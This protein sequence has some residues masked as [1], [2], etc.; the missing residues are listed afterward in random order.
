MSDIIPFPRSKDKL[1]RD[2]K[3]AYNRDDLEEMY[4]L[5][6]DYEEHYELD[7][8][9]SLLKCAMLYRMNHFLELREEAIILLKQ[10]FANY[11]ELVIYYV[12]SLNGLG[13]YF[14][15]VEVI[16]QIIDEVQNHK[17]R[18]ELLPLKSYALSQLEQHNRHAASQLQQ[19]DTLEIRDQINTILALIDNS[20]YTYKD[21][22]ANLLNEADIRNNVVSIMLEYLRFAEYEAEVH[23]NKFNQSLSVVPKNLPG[24]EQTAMKLEVIPEVVKCL[25]NEGTQLI[26]EALHVMNNHAILLYPI[27]I[28]T[29]GAVS[30][31]IKAYTN[32]FKSMLGI[33][34]PQPVDDVSDFIQQLDQLD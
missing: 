26:E 22:V 4:G 18:M 15:V 12:E 33:V 23:I 5:F 7:E 16:D 21:T 2:I 1:I 28:T 19:F 8:T 27:N 6:D 34:Q 30:Q 13:Q 32:Y 29:I 25:D 14:E 24:V 17:T 10:G 20:Q 9:L 3:L 11:D 31:W